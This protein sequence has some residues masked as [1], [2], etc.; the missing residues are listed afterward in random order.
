MREKYER[1]ELG[2]EDLQ[3]LFGDQEGGELE[4]LEGDYGEEGEDDQDN[5]D[6]DDN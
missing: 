6:G 2:S 5:D 4:Q 3:A 1:G